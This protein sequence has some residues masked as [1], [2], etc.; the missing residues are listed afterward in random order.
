MG[1]G[2]YDRWGKGENERNWHGQLSSQ[3]KGVWAKEFGM[4]ILKKW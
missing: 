2:D 4:V 3:A 1:T